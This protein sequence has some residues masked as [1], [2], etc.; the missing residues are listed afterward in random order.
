MILKSLDVD[1]V[2]V[3]HCCRRGKYSEL[4]YGEA[5]QDIITMID[6]RVDHDVSAHGGWINLRDTSLGL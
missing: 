5:L 2:E 6:D 4:L 1:E 3:Y